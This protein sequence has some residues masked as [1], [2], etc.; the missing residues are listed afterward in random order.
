MSAY[1]IHNYS[2]IEIRPFLEEKLGVNFENN[3]DLY[4][5]N[6]ENESIKISQIREITN[7]IVYPPSKDQY[8]T[9]VLQNFE[10]ATVPA[11]NAF[12]KTLEEHPP[13]VKI[14][15]VCNK[16]KGILETIISRCQIL[17]TESDITKNLNSAETVNNEKLEETFKTIS[18]GTYADIID[19]VEQYKKR[20]L[21]IPFVVELT[22]FFHQKCQKSPSTQLTLALENLQ[23]CLAQLE[24]NSNVSL[25]LEDHL[26][27]I[28][29]R[30]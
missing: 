21:A 2:Q 29:S 9:V 3:A 18:E 14:I 20:E 8:K 26:F 24:Q 13:Y 25:T 19:L 6:Q 22:K 11:Q 15:L 27:D 23:V 16:T 4:L 28:K 1:L 17:K 7:Q 12:L 5:I 10:K 30:F